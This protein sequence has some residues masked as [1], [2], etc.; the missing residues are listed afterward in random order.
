MDEI[1]LPIPSWVRIQ[2]L[3]DRD[4]LYHALTSRPFISPEAALAEAQLFIRCIQAVVK[5]PL[6]ED[7]LEKWAIRSA[8]ATNSEK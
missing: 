4:H 5:D 7:L 1:R 2:S 3:L 8:E 6:L